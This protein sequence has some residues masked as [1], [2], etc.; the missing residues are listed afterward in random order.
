LTPRKKWLHIMKIEHL[1]SGKIRFITTRRKKWSTV[2]DEVAPVHRLGYN[3]GV[4]EVLAVAINRKPW[5]TADARLDLLMIRS[6]YRRIEHVVQ[7]PSP[8]KGNAAD[9]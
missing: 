1:P 4:K 2:R 8:E 6:G 5:K 9:D 3:L 7:G